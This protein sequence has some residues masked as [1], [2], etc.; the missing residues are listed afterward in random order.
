M[1]S[2]IASP[3]GSDDDKSVGIVQTQFA[4]LFEQVDCIFTPATPIT[5]PKIGQTKVEI[6]GVREEVR[7]AATRF[8]RG[9]N[10]LGFPAISIP[11]GFSRGGLPI[12]LQMIAAARQEDLLLHVA[13]AMEDALALA[14][15]RPSMAAGQ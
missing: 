14:G 7:M 13:A 4:R 5:A 8:T 11:C 12:G 6:G 9:M 10:G 2:E 1:A 3:D 15:R